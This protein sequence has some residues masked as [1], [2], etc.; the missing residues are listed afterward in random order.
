MQSATHSLRD[1]FAQLYS[2]AAVERFHR[3][4]T[5]ELFAA[6]LLEGGIPT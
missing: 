2:R 6:G 4:A 5:V 3:Q 1:A